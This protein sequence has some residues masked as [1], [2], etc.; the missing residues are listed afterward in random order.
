MGPS[1]SGPYI[2]G[3]K[4]ASDG[5]A[6]PWAWGLI[7]GRTAPNHE[8]SVTRPG[9]NNYSRAARFLNDTGSNL[10]HPNNP[11]GRSMV[12]S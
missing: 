2:R 4:A 1:A 7:E 8:T 11:S 6:L 10:L 9:S 5:A 12:V 3:R